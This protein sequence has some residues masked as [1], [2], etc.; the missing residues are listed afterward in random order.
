MRGRLL[1][2]LSVVAVA[3]VGI[4]TLLALRGSGSSGIAAGGVTIDVSGLRPGHVIPVEVSLP[5]AKHAKAPVF[6]VRKGGSPVMA[7][8]GISTH[9]GCRLLWPGDPTYGAGFTSRSEVEFED[10][11]GG[12]VFAL[13]GACI[14][15]PCPRGLDRYRVTVVDHKAEI[16]LK[17]LLTG[18]P[19]GSS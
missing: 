18:P 10:P 13:D 1:I 2:V 5:N 6:V 19:R 3:L 17:H 12:S 4:V 8:L 7:L 9:L 11:C 16:D 14:G 15:G